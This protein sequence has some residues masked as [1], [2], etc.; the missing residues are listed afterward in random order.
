VERL[1]CYLLTR[2]SARYLDEILAQV[3]RFADDVLVLDSGSTDATREIALRRGARFETR[4]LDD[5]ASQRNFAAS[6]CAFD[7]VIAVDSDE[8]P[9]DALV[10]ALVEL[11]RGGLAEDAYRVRREWLVLGR[12]VHAV[13]PIPCPDHPIR[14]YDRRLVRYER[15]VHETPTGYRTLGLVDAAL[16]HRTFHTREELRAKMELYSDLA[17]R[18]LARAPGASR[19]RLRLKLLASPV[20]AFV[21]WWLRAGGWRDG[22]VG[23]A[24]GAYA[25]RTTYFKY[26]KALRLI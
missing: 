3:V 10:R 23:L 22:R 26:R 13:F 25:A 9:S 6:R 12:R 14:L 7:R 16:E 17:A 2:D 11:K 18:E 1:S 4:P 5:F 20:A 19:W 24:L 15:A 8:I 21:K